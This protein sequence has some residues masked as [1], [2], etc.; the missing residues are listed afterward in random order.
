MIV[1]TNET[2]DKIK[3]IFYILFYPICKFFE[4]LKECK[5]NDFWD[6]MEDWGYYLLGVNFW[7]CGVF[8]IGLMGYGLKYH[9]AQTI[10]PIILISVAIFFIIILPYFIHKIVNRK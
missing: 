3:L 6:F 1:M 9:F 5:G 2:K 4:I 10:I 7:I 8:V